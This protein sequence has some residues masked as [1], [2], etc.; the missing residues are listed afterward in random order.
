MKWMPVFVLASVVAN[1]TSASGQEVGYSETGLASIYANV[2]N[3]HVTASGAIY[4]NAKLTTA[5]N[6]LPFGTKVKVTNASN[7][8]S[9][10]LVVNDRGPMRRARI[11]DITPAA[12]AALR[13]D[14]RGVHKV[15]LAVVEIGSGNTTKT[16]HR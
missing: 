11:L 5:H 2:L 4:D 6:T 16:A 9:V 8:K 15:T 3:G 10:I 12:A 7:K 1:S 14:R 13:F